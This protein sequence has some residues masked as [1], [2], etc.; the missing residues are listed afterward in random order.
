VGS[1]LYSPVQVAGGLISIGDGHALQGDGEVTLAALE[2]SLRGS[3]CARESRSNG[4]ARGNAD[5]LHHDGIECRL[6]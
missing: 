3:L 5:A 1:I 4:L 6:G 2:T